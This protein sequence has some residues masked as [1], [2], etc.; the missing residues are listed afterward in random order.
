MRKAP[1]RH[2]DA[3]GFLLTELAVSLPIFVLL[4]TFLA[5]ALAWSWRSYQQEVA[6]AEL[7][8]EMHIAAVR[9]VESALLSDYIRQRQRGIYE[10]RQS[11]RDHEPFDRYWLSDGRLIFKTVT[12]PI[13][14]SFDRAGVHIT[15]FS[16]REDDDHPRLYHIELTGESTVTGHRY[17]LATSVYLRRDMGGM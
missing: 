7:R 2:S 12:F 8:Q 11:M 3:R 4:L 14:G 6:D 15:S 1:P 9:I 13:T 5:F 10:M 17:S 16:I